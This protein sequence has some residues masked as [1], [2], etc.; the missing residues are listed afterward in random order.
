MRTVDHAQ[1]ALGRA[2]FAAVGLAV[3]LLSAEAHAE[4]PPTDGAT[5]IRTNVQPTIDFRPWRGQEAR[6]GREL[7]WARWMMATESPTLDGD[8]TR[9]A[10]WLD[11]AAFREEVAL[12]RPQAGES[13]LTA[14]GSMVIA[15]LPVVGVWRGGKLKQ[16][17]IVRGYF[18]GK[19]IAI[20]W[21]IEF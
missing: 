15:G 6:F 18:R 3:S 9:P 12:L 17:H 20:G 13:A 1:R 10:P 14:I 16:R 11:L 19:G 4:D 8:T 21:R 7:T 2:A 5:L